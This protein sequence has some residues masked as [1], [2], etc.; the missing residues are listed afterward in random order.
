[1]SNVWPMDR[2]PESPA[3]TTELLRWIA[4]ERDAAWTA[5]LAILRAHRREDIAHF[6]ACLREHDRHTGELALLARLADPAAPVPTDP[7]FV[8]AE[9]FV[10]GAIDDPEALV[11]AMGRLEAGRIERYGQRPRGGDGDPGSLLDRLLERHLADARA[12][13]ASL[14]GLRE[15]RRAS[16]AA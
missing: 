15:A 5:R 4:Y 12:R 8:T 3:T 16:I 1:M 9:P 13:L 2:V 14:R 7:C 10:V 11:E 6:G